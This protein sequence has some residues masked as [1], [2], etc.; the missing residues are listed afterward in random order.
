MLSGRIENFAEYSQFKTLKDFN[1]SIEMFLLDHKKDFT[2]GELIAFKRLTKY[3]AKHYG[4]AN[5]KIATIVKAINELLNGYGVS[6]RTFERM[7]KKAEELG[8]LTRKHTFKTKGGQGHN[9]YIFQPF[10]KTVAPK[11]EILAYRKN[12]ET[13]TDSKH[14]QVENEGETISL[15]ETNNIK[16]LS[17]RI[18]AFLDHTYVNDNVPKEFTNLVKCFFDDA[19]TIEEYWKMVKIDTYNVKNKLD[20]ED[21]LETAI[22]S[23]KQMV[24]RLKQGKVKNPIAYFKGVLHKQITDLY[25]AKTAPIMEDMDSLFNYGKEP[26][27]QRRM[28]LF[29]YQ[30]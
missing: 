5:A 18:P 12:A 17:K 13:I 29:S 16:R 9:V 14:Q 2:R 28:V 10:N 1:T 24:S 4:V 27:T 7:I 6:R 26:S 3:A 15:L 11:T 23:F 20:K 21:I 22:H 8:I 19:M 30:S 25:T